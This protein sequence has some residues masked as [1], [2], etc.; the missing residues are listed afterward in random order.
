MLSVDLHSPQIQGFF[1]IPMDHLRGIYNFAHD[2]EHRNLSDTVVVSPDFGSVTRCN[3]FAEM[4][5][6]PLAI[7]DKRRKTDKVIEIANFIG[8]V[9]GK[10]AVLVDDVLSTGTSLCN[11]AISAMEHGAK[12]V[13]AC[14]THAVLA[15]N[16]IETIDKSPLDEILVLDTIEIPKEKLHPKIKIMSIA[17]LVSEAI[18][19]IHFGRSIGNLYKAPNGFSIDGTYEME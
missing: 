9:D 13:S 19:C 12:R 18:K 1:D 10:H 11:A 5:N 14:V 16:A 2:Y 4:L 15:G 7:V 6:V 8:D 17:P 3:T